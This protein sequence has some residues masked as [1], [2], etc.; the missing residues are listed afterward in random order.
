MEPINPVQ[1]KT[2]PGAVTYPQISSQ[3]PQNQQPPNKSKKQVGIIM[4]FLATIIFLLALIALYKT[5]IFENPIN[6]LTTKVENIELKKF[7]SNEEF[8]EYTERSVQ[9]AGYLSGF[10]ESR[11][12]QLEDIGA[13]SAAFDTGGSISLSPSQPER[14]SETNVQVVGIDEPDIVKT[15]GNNIFF[16]GHIYG[17]FTMDSREMS[18]EPEQ[19]ILNPAYNTKVIKAFPPTELK[20]IS[21]IEENGEMLLFDKM[22]VNLSGNKYSGYDVSDP[23]TPTRKWVKELESNIIIETARKFE[24][25]LYLVTKTHIYSSSPC[26]IP[27]I[28]EGMTIACTDIYYPPSSNSLDT[29]YTILVVDPQSGN[30]DKSTSF[31]GSGNASVVYMSQENIYISFSYYEN[32]LNF[33]LNFLKSQGKDIISDEIINKLDTLN[34][35]DISD[36]AKMLEFNRI[37]EGYLL[38]LSDDQRKLIEN[39]MQNKIEAYMKEHARDLEKTGIARFDIK[40]LEASS[41][42]VIPGSPLNQFSLDE[43]KGFLRIATTTSNS[44]TGSSDSFSDVYVLNED[45]KV[46]GK[47]TDLGLTERIYSARFVGDRGYLVTF[48]QIDP[49]YVLDLSDPNNP[50]MTGELKIPG[51]SSYLHPLQENIILGVGQEGSN[52]KVSMFDVSDPSNPKEISKY[53]LSEYWSD[54]SSNHHAFL[55]DEKHSIFFMPAGQSGYI[56]SYSGSTLALKRVV[57]GISATRVLYLND[58]LYILGNE[59]MVVLNEAD[60]E[61]IAS[62]DYR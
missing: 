23:E 33:L 13:P 61:E 27:L 45:L 53:E 60:W 52:A 24:G 20:T 58:Y 2:P 57:T 40:N 4:I 51:Y 11:S 25:K 41:S 55:Q 7:T 47:I 19:F 50:K 15:D 10:S 56:F 26:P 32:M 36:E 42:E 21:Y 37:F 43:H 34:S 14:V 29:T 46:T 22:L 59:K 8:R 28:K 5:R 54:V 48:R 62:Y 31:M 38:G 35:Y 30:V 49:F 3:L 1:Q 39:E 17:I 9:S 16:S 6:P 12:M 18:I 44:L